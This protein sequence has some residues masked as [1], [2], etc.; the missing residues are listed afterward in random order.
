MISNLTFYLAILCALWLGAA[1]GVIAAGL[2]I[3]AKGPNDPFDE[4]EANAPYPRLHD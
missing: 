4:M 1:I 3:S 2:C